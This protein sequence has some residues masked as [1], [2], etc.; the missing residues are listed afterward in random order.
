MYILLVEGW[1]TYYTGMVSQA[2]P[3]NQY[4]DKDDS[5][6][7]KE[8]IDKR[9]GWKLA[10]MGLVIMTAL[11]IAPSCL[12]ALLIIG[13]VEKNPGP[14]ELDILAGLCAEATDPKVRDCPSKI[15]RGT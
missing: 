12:H 14:Y 1:E 2:P 11:M 5:D 9:P 15:K 6:Q 10:T 3:G 8:C 13:G 7:G 4:V